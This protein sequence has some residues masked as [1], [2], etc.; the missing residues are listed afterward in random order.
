[1]IES[2]Y[3]CEQCDKTTRHRWTEL[4]GP[5]TEDPFR[6][7]LRCQVRYYGSPCWGDLV[8][9]SVWDAPMEEGQEEPLNHVAWLH[10]TNGL[11][12]RYA[13]DDVLRMLAKGWRPLYERL[14]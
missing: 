6:D 10:T 2:V 7:R 13:T 8:L 12:I 4:P 11:M 1:M 3:R 14:P 9:I 5:R